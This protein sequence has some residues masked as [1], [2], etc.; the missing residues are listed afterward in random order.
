MSLL[1]TKFEVK[2]LG[3]WL[4]PKGI[5]QHCSPSSSMMYI[6]TRD[7]SDYISTIKDLP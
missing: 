4:S 2:Q 6:T 3:W 5:D 7:R 1:Y